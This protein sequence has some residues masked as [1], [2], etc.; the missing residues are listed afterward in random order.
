MAGA[1]AT[2]VSEGLVVADEVRLEGDVRYVGPVDVAARAELLAGATALL[3]PTLYVEP[4]GGVAVEAMLSG[5]PAVT[6]DWGAFVETVEEGV[7]GFRFGT[8][9]EAV[10]GVALAAQLEPAAVRARAIERYSLEAVAPEFLAW[11]ARLATLR[12]GGWYEMTAPDAI[13]RP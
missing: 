3:V 2:Q 12:A 9:A 11:F 1:G 13:M 6:S 8:L 7:T 5:T 4:F 10:A